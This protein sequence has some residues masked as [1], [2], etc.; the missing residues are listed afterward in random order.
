MEFLLLNSPKSRT[1]FH[2]VN[3]LDRRPCMW[4]LRQCLGTDLEDARK[5]KK[6]ATHPKDVIHKR[7]SPWAKFNQLY[8]VLHSGVQIL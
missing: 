3:V 6:G 2:E 7:T 1:G 8:V 5:F 4:E